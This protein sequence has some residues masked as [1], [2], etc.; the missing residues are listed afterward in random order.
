MPT[1]HPHS[2]TTPHPCPPTL[3]GA[4][5]LTPTDRDLYESTLAKS[6]L[7]LVYVGAAFMFLG[8]TSYTGS[9]SAFYSTI[10]DKNKLPSVPTAIITSPVAAARLEFLVIFGILKTGVQAL[11]SGYA[12]A[13]FCQFTAFLLALSAA[14]IISPWITGTPQEKN[15]LRSPKTYSNTN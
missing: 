9:Y 6:I 3:L 10:Y 4:D 7:A 11:A 5:V 13:T 12:F 14:I 1:C 15:I 8:F 2:L